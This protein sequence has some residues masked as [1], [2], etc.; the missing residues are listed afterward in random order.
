MKRL[1]KYFYNIDIDNFNIYKEY[2]YFSYEENIYA[3]VKNNR[4]I[5]EIIELYNL[6][7]LLAQD[8]IYL[9]EIIKN[10]KGELVT[11]Y[12]DIAYVLLKINSSF[13]GEV[14]LYD[15]INT[16][17]NLNNLD[18]SILCR[19]DIAKLWESKIDYF[20]YQ[21]SELGLD[22]KIILNSFSYYIGLSE[23]AISIVNNINNK[24]PNYKKN[25]GIAHKR[26][27]YPNMELDYY[28]PLNIIIDLK[29]RDIA[30]YIKYNYI[31]NDSINYDDIDSIIM[32]DYD[33]NMFFARLLFPTYYFDLY[34]KII[35]NKLEEQELLMVIS[36]VNNYEKFLKTIWF[37]LNKKYK[38]EKV[39]W[40]CIKKES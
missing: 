34:E 30:E 17:I 8:N 6:S 32:D 9:H 40:L 23:N 24:Y 25:L 31:Y 13:S 27:S 4:D 39:E 22:K 37:I 12:D 2:M 28:N 36:K 19:N 3:L 38:M 7:I 20:E 26:I 35:E 18:N 11:Y 1:L 33:A 14:C 5:K 10:N 15:I 29:I 16:K 21:V